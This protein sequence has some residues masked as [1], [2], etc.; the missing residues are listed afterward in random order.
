MNNVTF[1]NSTNSST[2][3]P[4]PSSVQPVDSV[5]NKTD[6]WALIAGILIIV[7][8]A[9][10]KYRALRASRRVLPMVNVLPAATSTISEVQAPGIS[11]A[12]A[13]F[14]GAV[15]LASI[16]TDEETVLSPWAIVKNVN[17]GLALDPC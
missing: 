1:Q 14:N 11:H 4:N 5:P 12:D 10:W 2:P 6:L 13:N 9:I 15:G 8:A 7:L 17:N 16:E 3:I